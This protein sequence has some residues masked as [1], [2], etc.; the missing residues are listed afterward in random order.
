[1][2]IQDEKQINQAHMRLLENS[3][4]ELKFVLQAHMK[5]FHLHTL[6]ELL[7]PVLKKHIGDIYSW[8]LRCTSNELEC[9]NGESDE[10]CR[11]YVN[12]VRE[13]HAPRRQRR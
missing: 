2:Q 3:T 1:M 13:Q 11:N 9:V 4:L 5:T 6:P 10:V 12:R 7:P 8:R